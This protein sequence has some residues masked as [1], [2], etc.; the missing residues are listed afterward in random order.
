[1]N[2]FTVRAVLSD[3][4]WSDY[5]RFDALLAA[6]DIHDVI[7]SDAGIFYKLPPG[8]YS[9]IGPL[10]ADQ[11]ILAVEGCAAQ[12]VSNFN[13]LVT[14]GLSTWRGLKLAS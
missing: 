6:R 10:N 1:M 4:S 7:M 2:V 9:Y 3:A 13:V 14:Q 11:L 8:V 12:V 5:I